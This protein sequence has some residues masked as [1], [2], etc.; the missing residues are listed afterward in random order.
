[1]WSEIMSDAVRVLS[2]LI[3]YIFANRIAKVDPFVRLGPI[4]DIDSATV[5]TLI[6][7][8]AV[9]MF[10]FTLFTILLG[11]LQPLFPDRIYGPGA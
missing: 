9:L 8:F 10:V 7:G 4:L 6:R 11:L 1:M 3:I 5:V 2:A